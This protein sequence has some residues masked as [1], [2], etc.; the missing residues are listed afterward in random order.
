MNAARH[1]QVQAIFAE[2]CELP[3]AEIVAFVQARCGDDAGLAQQ[4]YALLEADACDDGF[5]ELGGAELAAGPPEAIMGERGY[6][7][8]KQIGEGGM[9][10]VHLAERSDGSFRQ[11]VA[12]KMMHG[13][14]RPSRDALLR[15]RA[16]R[17]IL[18]ALN[19]PNIARLLDGGT[20]PGGAP[21]LVMEYIEGERL[22][23]WCASRQLDVKA[24]LALFLKVCDAVAAAHQAL[25]V[26]RD[27]K[28][29]NIMV[30]AAGEPK[31]LD[32]G[33]AKVL[34]AEWFAHSLAHTRTGAM[35]MTL[36]YA[37][38]EQ[39]RG[40][41]VGTASD[42]FALGVVLYE[43]L[44]GSTPYR[45]PEGD[46]VSLARAVCEE[47]PEAPSRSQARRDS[48]VRELPTAP[49]QR[50][51]PVELTLRRQLRGDLDAIV[52]KALRKE[53][54]E[55]Y[56]SVEQ[57]ADDIRRYLDGL[58]VLARRG[59]TS[60]RVKKFLWR[61]RWPV[62]AGSLLL[63]V[64]LGAVLLLRGQLARTEIERDKANRVADF[65][66]Q[67]FERS[68][69][70]H[71]EV[72][73]SAQATRITVREVMD[74]NAPRITRELGGSPEVQA[75]LLAV[76]ARIYD[77]LALPE[78]AQRYGE[79]ALELLQQ[80]GQVP[81]R[82]SV[83]VRLFLV[84][85]LS[86]RGLYP[87][88]LAQAQRA[89]DEAA[90][91][92]RG[93]DFDHARALRA[94][95]AIQRNLGA[96]ELAHADAHAARA[97]FER[98]RGKDDPFVAGTIRD[99][100]MIA[101]GRGDFAR[102]D[103][104]AREALAGLRANVDPAQLVLSNLRATQAACLTGLGDFDGAAQAL[105]ENLAAQQAVF[106][107]D[108]LATAIA[109]NDLANVLNQRQQYAE[110]E[111][112]LRTALAI[113]R[114]QL[115]P[116]HASQAPLLLNLSRAVFEQGRHDE[117]I[118]LQRQ[119]LFLTPKELEQQYAVA[120]NNLGYKLYQVGRLAE[121]EARLREALALFLKVAP[122]HPDVAMTQSSLGRLLTEIGRAAEARPLIEQALALRRD[123]L[124]P[125]HWAIADSRSLLGACLLA[126]GKRS[127]AEPLLRDGLAGLTSALG[128]DHPRTLRAQK[129]LDAWAK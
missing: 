79:A 128:P 39:V 90:A 88:A 58:P 72:R 76:V 107:N 109:M 38:P 30:N 115:G 31:L 27:L 94:R 46:P 61:Q 89:I 122:R 114:E 10:Q 47:Q 12:I 8:I 108:N 40:E 23:H 52:L 53:V 87:A 35:P 127:E 43:L 105:R 1:R 118:E 101:A 95:G 126:L 121:S 98:V 112:L 50:V 18:A 63:G 111:Q 83:Q 80:T 16:E 7:L 110:A 49:N 29:S 125:G 119:A 13:S 93:D 65:I 67:M 113:E 102:C 75:S 120:L 97:M 116:Q 96:W 55:R 85:S 124:P 117:G 15:F 14:Q 20:L 37:S 59:S 25:I 41:A 91:I 70:H 3:P 100:A 60:Y 22:D 82:N 104:L 51:A 78:R 103:E 92:A 9:G 17:Q 74:Q 54:A 4:V 19:H 123:V 99:L 66:V 56:R 129:R 64:L 73:D 57:F 36:A 24:R 81:S 71:D 106:G 62:G 34:N 44:T 26:H 32:F 48:S 68:N 21:F 33:I 6:R 42:V 45:V 5:L 11:K 2:A 69:P 86:S 28:P 84:Q 77:G